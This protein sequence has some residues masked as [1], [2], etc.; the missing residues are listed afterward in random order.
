MKV[1]C[2]ENK[3]KFMKCDVQKFATS[4]IVSTPIIM[5]VQHRQSGLYY[6]DG[7]VTHSYCNE[8]NSLTLCFL[9]VFSL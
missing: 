5:A 4:T 2:Q 1:C 6:P 3:S 9:G 8:R 7:G